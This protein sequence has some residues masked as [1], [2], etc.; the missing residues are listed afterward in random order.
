VNALRVVRITLPSRYYKPG[1]HKALERSI[2]QQLLRYA[3][4][5]AALA[6]GWLQEVRPAG[7][8]NPSRRFVVYLTDKKWY[9]DIPISFSLEVNGQVI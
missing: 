1:I 3:S 5:Q 4:L 8:K 7:G 6:D 2:S 9:H